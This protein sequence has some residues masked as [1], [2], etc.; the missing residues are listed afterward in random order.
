MTR[1]TLYLARHGEAD[2]LGALT[3]RGREQCRLLGRRLAPLPIDVVWHSPLPRAADSAREIARC[4]PRVLVDEAPEL[5]DHIPCVPA[6]AEMPSS[7]EPFFDGFGEEEDAV[8]RRIARSLTDRFARPHPDGARETHEVLITHAYPVAWMVRDAL[9]APPRS[10][11]S[12]SG[13]TNTALT[14]IEYTD[15]LP[16]V[17][18]VDDRSHLPGPSAPA[19]AMPS[20]PTDGTPTA[21]ADGTPDG[22]TSAPTDGTPSAPAGERRAPEDGPR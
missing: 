3:D 20:T 8:G 6:A 18:C 15:D 2:A 5:I 21:P 7:W 10:W 19:D 22:T 1:R 17:R 13:I 14:V 12:L 9:G 11:M 4:L 16:L